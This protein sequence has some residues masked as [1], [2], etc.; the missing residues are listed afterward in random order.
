MSEERNGDIGGF[1]GL[2]PLELPAGD[3]MRMVQE[4]R[5]WLKCHCLLVLIRA[6]KW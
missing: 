2:V 5:L 4:R 3:F 6:Q 1:N